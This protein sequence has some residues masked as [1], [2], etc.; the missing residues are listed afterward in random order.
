[1]AKNRRET[2]P[3]AR[4]AAGVSDGNDAPRTDEKAVQA[5][6]REEI[7]ALEEYAEVER[8]TFGFSTETGAKIERT[9]MPVREATEDAPTEDLSRTTTLRVDRRF[10]ET[11]MKDDTPRPE[12]K[13]PIDD[14]A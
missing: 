6:L 3:L 1:M 7:R 2:D 8:Q 4:R 12:I 11:L 5:E 14:G 9:R 10:V 13:R